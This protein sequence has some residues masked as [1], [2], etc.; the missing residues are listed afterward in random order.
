MRFHNYGSYIPSFGLQCACFDVLLP[1][2]RGM[3]GYEGSVTCPPL[4]W[5]TDVAF[6]HGVVSSDVT[7]SALPKR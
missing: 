6:P 3:K 2:G 4:M 5:Y 7:S 1:L